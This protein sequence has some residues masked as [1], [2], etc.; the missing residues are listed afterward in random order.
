MPKYMTFI[1]VTN[2]WI[3][4]NVTKIKRVLLAVAQSRRPQGSFRIRQSGGLTDK[5]ETSD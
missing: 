5:P 4:Q 3:I 1:T 2:S